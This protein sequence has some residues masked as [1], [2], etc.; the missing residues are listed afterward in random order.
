LQ[1]AASPVRVPASLQATIAARIDRLGTVAKRTL[2][3]ASVIGMRF[4]AD[5]LST[6]VDFVEMD[7]LASAELIDPVAFGRDDE[8]VFRHPLVRAVAYESQLKSERARLH[9]SLADSLSARNPDNADANAALIA[10]HREAAGDL[11]GA[12]EWHMRAGGWSQFRDVVA[13]NASWVR[14][15]DVADRLPDDDPDRTALRIMPRTLLCANAWRFDTMPGDT[16]FD[17]LRELC[18]AVGDDVSLC[19]GMAGTLTVN[20]F[21]GRYDEAVRLAAEC[22]AVVEGLADTSLVVD[23]IAAAGNAMVQAGRAVDALR[24]A[25]L[26]ISAGADA[27]GRGRILDSPVAL[28]LG[29]RGV[30]RLMLG[31]GG[32][33]DDLDASVLAARS[34]DATAFATSLLYK[35]GLGTRI[36]AVKPDASAVSDTAEAL[37]KADRS[38]D[39]FAREAAMITRCTVLLEQ[40]G[41][42]RDE[43]LRLL[44]QYRE[45]AFR[46]RAMGWNARLAEVEE[47]RQAALSGDLDGAIATVRTSLDRLF[48]SGEMMS[49]GFAT[50]IL[51]ESLLR[52]GDPCDVAE[53]AA[54]IERLAAVPVDP[55]FVVHEL[56]LLRM[57]ALLARS[58]GD[59]TGYRVYAQRYR[60]M[61]EDLKFAR[62]MAIAAEM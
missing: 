20:L 44:A 45:P 57:R 52:R 25:E 35:Y 9:A 32:W 37:E 39:N 1:Q 38:G 14:A 46:E 49:R 8:Y 48:D 31:I 10:E 47:A 2:N 6:L 54:A 27:D 22:S 41:E 34:A 33:R 61:A 3:A 17:E 16:G 4:D 23:I 19:L 51:V 43:G 12:L 56:P 50:T 29:L 58:R 5:L 60:T 53:A 18:L 40:A 30:S 15:R 13:A 36:G 11:R 7:E 59:E 42:L 28:A 55:G 21:H 26:A 62:H 24:L